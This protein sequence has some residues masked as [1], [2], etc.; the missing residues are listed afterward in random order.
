MAGGKYIKINSESGGT[1][2]SISRSKSPPG[3]TYI[4]EAAAVMIPPED[5]IER[6]SAAV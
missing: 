2:N 6:P 4:Q 5:F 3:Y 1:R